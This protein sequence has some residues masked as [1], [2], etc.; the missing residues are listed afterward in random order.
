M[1]MN[2]GIVSLKCH[3]NRNKQLPDTERVMRCLSGMKGNFLVPF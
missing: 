1:R 2:A 3:R